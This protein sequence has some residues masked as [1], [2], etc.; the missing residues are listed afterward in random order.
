MCV[1]KKENDQYDWDDD[2]SSWLLGQ[3]G[4]SIVTSIDFSI[5]KLLNIH[6]NNT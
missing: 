5:E 6:I 1:R 3:W 2:L 4:K